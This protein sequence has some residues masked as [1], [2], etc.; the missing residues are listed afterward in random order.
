M[1]KRDEIEAYALIDD[2]R[3]QV[4]D[5]NKNNAGLKNKVNF[6]KALHESETRKRTPYDH[7]PP[8]IVTVWLLDRT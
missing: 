1:T 5:L 8:R 2:L 3:N 7:I 4:R 6:F